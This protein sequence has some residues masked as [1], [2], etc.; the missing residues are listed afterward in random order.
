[1]RTVVQL[2]VEGHRLVGILH[3]PIPEKKQQLNF[4]G[5]IGILQSNTGWL[6]R[7]SR[8]DLSAHLADFTAEL[9]Y[10][11]FRFDMPGL[12]DSPGDLPSEVLPFFEL[13]QK[14]D[15]VRFLSALQVEIVRRYE[16]SGLILLGHCGNATTAVYSVTPKPP[17]QICGLI[18]L[19]PSFVWYRS[20][21][22][23]TR[24]L[25]HGRASLRA[26]LARM[27][28]GRK[29]IGAYSSIKGLGQGLRGGQAPADSNERLLSCYRNLITGE[30]PILVITAPPRRKANYFDYVRFVLDGR[31]PN[32]ID[33]VEIEGTDHAF[34]AGDGKQ[35]VF[36]N[37]QKWLRANFPCEGSDLCDESKATESLGRDIPSAAEAQMAPRG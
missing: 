1:M 21:G 4:R 16:L 13:T 25:L 29:V 31:T 35:R 5:R 22:K 14:G 24:R 34:L 10:P 26:W 2:E 23:S 18:L 36:K 19:D 20:P 8:G 9:G 11:A 32:V 27:P 7:S 37:V 33:Y 15:H 28:G 17:K 6:P 12:G 3:W 30:L